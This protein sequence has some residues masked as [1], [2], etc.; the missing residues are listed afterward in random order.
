MAVR[1]KNLETSTIMLE[2][3]LTEQSLSRPYMLDEN[4]T[5]YLTMKST[6]LQREYRR[7][8]YG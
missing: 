1:L 7:R 2:L 6:V 8:L 4:L 3:T 5:N